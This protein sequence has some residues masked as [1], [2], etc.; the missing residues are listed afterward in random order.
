MSASLTRLLAVSPRLNTLLEEKLGLPRSGQAKPEANAA[1]GPPTPSASVWR[2]QLEHRLLA[3]HREDRASQRL[4]T[5][6]GVGL[7][8]A[9]ALAA[10]VTDPSLFRSGREFAAFLG[11]VPR[12]NSS[13]GKDRLGRISKRVDGYLRKLLVVGATSVIRRAK[14]GELTA[15]A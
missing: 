4:A 7:I 5:I 12:Q 14:T 13:G 1:P 2:S 15:A 10:S 8:S 6:P 3:W 9:T 11:V